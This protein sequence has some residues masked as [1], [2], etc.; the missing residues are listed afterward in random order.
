MINDVKD[1]VVLSP[2]QSGEEK[3]TKEINDFKKVKQWYLTPNFKVIV[4]NQ[5]L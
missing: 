1:I 3:T 4:G 2:I 5:T